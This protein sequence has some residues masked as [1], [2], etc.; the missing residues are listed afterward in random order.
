MLN[1]TMQLMNMLPVMFLLII[2]Y[3]A[4]YLAQNIIKI[5]KLEDEIDN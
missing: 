1:R 3:F 4:I 2:L 5:S